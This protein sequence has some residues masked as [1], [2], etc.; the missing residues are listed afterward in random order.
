MSWTRG[1]PRPRSGRGKRVAIGIGRTARAQRHRVAA[2]HLQLAGVLAAGPG[3]T[4]F[5]T[6][7]ANKS[8]PL[9]EAGLLATAAPYHQWGRISVCRH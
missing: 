3:S 2:H 9:N 8:K 1:S 4:V 5:I 6:E 7:G